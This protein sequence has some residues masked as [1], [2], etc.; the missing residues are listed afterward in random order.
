VIRDAAGIDPEIAALERRRAAQRFDNYHLAAAEVAARRHLRPGLDADGAAA[1]I[2]A[3]GS[4]QT[5]RF[6]VVEQGWE[7][8][9][10]RRWVEASLTAA[11]LG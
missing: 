10:Y 3:I 1:V 2:W 9:R 7:V 8:A 4:P 5:Y 11:L 6:L